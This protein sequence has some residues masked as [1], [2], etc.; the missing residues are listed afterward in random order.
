VRIAHPQVFPPF[1]EVSNGNSIGLAVDILRAAVRA[2]IEVEIRG[3]IPLTQAAPRLG[4]TDLAMAFEVLEVSGRAKGALAASEG[5][6]VPLGAAG[7]NQTCQT[8]T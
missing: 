4:A 6:M 3:L 7:V 5:S 8:A 1:C 2:D